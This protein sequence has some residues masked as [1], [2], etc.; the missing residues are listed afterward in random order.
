MTGVKVTRLLSVLVVGMLLGIVQLEAQGRVV[1]DRRRIGPDERLG[2][3][4]T[5]YIADLIIV[6]GNPLDR[7]SDLRNVSG[8]VSNGRLFEVS[9]LRGRWAEVAETSYERTQR[10]VLDGLSKQGVTLE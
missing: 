5:G 3:V 8:V 6:E 7:V 1:D 4:E 2:Q 9:D 10:R